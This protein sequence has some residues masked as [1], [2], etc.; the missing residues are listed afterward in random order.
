MLE[1]LGF[2]LEIYGEPLKDSEQGHNTGTQQSPASESED[3]LG[4]GK[5]GKGVQPSQRG[6]KRYFRGTWKRSV[7]DFAT[8]LG[9]EGEV[10]SGR[11]PD[12]ALGRPSGW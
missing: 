11:A 4:R 8:V 9:T 7:R 2:H 6:A 3:G 1:S 12:F 5:S 10:D